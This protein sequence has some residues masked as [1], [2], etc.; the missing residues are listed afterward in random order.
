[1]SRAHTGLQLDFSKIR[2]TRCR[3]E[4]I[5]AQPCPVCG[6]RQRQNEINHAVQRRRVIAESVRPVLEAELPAPNTLESIDDLARRAAVAFQQFFRALAPLSRQGTDSA[7]VLEAARSLNLLQHNAQATQPRP[8]VQQGRHLQRALSAHHRAAKFYLEAYSAATLL[9]SQRLAQKGQEQLDLATSAAATFAEERRMQKQVLSASVD[10]VFDLLARTT[11]AVDSTHSDIPLLDADMRGAAIAG[12]ILAA[13]EIPLPGAGVVALWP[14]MFVDALMDRE[15]YTTRARE[16]LRLL[17]TSTRSIQLFKEETWLLNQTRFLQLLLDNSR[18]LEAILAAARHDS[19]SVRAI[20]V[21]AQDLFEGPFRHYIATL[22]SIRG[23]RSYTRLVEQD[24][25]GL[26]GQA[27]QKFGV[28]LAFGRS[29]RLRNASAHLDYRVDGES[30]LLSPGRPCEERISATEF[31]DACLE[32]VEELL[33]MQ[34]AVELKLIQSAEMSMKGID[35][36]VAVRALMTLSG[37]TAVHYLENQDVAKISAVGKPTAT[38]ELSAALTPNIHPGIEHL[39]LR[40]ASSDGETTFAVPLTPIRRF[41]QIDEVEGFEKQL[42]F[43]EIGLAATLD[44]EVFLRRDT[45]LHRIAILAG[46][47]V[48]EEL[49][50]AIRRIRLLWQ[51]CL[52]VGESQMASDLKLLIRCIRLKS[53]GIAVDAS[54]QRALD[55]LSQLEREPTD[56]PFLG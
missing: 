22:L 4:R 51:C 2:C 20:L 39:E 48:T 40:I 38:L 18:S 37:Y 1:M 17:S 42:A 53:D 5:L 33:S 50:S 23:K 27:L 24:A 49:P 44:E 26:L 13:D 15:A 52:N 35:T 28:D 46:Q 16:V 31:G 54:T 14:V 3:G 12:E 30:V 25:G 43:M 29:V 11:F 47:Q 41:S 19:Q 34:T 55:R 6:L 7:A 10:D 45:F 9:E 21:F 32:L 56:S 36:E 8:W